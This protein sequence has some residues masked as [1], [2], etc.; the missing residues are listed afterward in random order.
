MPHCS[1]DL[2][3]TVPNPVVQWSE[4]LPWLGGTVFAYTTKV[5]LCMKKYQPNACSK[6]P[7]NDAEPKDSAGTYE[8][9]TVDQCASRDTYTDVSED[10][11]FIRVG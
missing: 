11:V 7:S 5:M 1:F 4:K 8:V 9:S 6:A 2:A 10:L 3:S